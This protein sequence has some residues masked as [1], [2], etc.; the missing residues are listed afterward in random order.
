MN[1]HYARTLTSRAFQMLS[2]SCMFYLLAPF[3]STHMTGKDLFRHLWGLGRQCSCP[4]VVS[5][6]IVMICACTYKHKYMHNKSSRQFHWHYA[7]TG[8]SNMNWPVALIHPSWNT[9]SEKIYRSLISSVMNV[10]ILTCIYPMSSLV[11][12]LHHYL[13]MDESWQANHCL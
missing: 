4:L 13:I 7:D 12:L 10:C 3:C 5:V 2:G 6:P 1:I 11:I 9:L 8:I